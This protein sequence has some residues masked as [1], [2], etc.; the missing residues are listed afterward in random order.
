[1]TRKSTR[2]TPA[3]NSH[4]EYSLTKKT[5]ENVL[6]EGGGGAAG[7]TVNY[8]K[9]SRD[10]KGETPSGKNVHIDKSLVIDKYCFL[11]IFKHV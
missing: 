1:M 6:G 7:V 4:T 9:Q 8:C 10:K 5:I 2:N 11:K 3:N